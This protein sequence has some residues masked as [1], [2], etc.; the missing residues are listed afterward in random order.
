MKVYRLTC[1]CIFKGRAGLREGYPV[2]CHQRHRGKLTAIAGP[3]VS[4]E[5]YNNPDYVPERKQPK[6]KLGR[7]C[8][9]FHGS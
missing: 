3:G 9:E 6:K 2:T 7:A 1:G 4:L 8:R 5:E